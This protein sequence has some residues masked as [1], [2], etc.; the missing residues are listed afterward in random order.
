M[1]FSDLK[2]KVYSILQMNEYSLS[3]SYDYWQIDMFS[4]PT[5]EYSP[6]AMTTYLV[7]DCLHQVHG[8][9]SSFDRHLVTALATCISPRSVDLL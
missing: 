9:L 4:F 8:Y 5:L 6:G 3:L 7:L 2:S 1:G